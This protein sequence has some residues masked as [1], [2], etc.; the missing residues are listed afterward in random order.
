MSECFVSSWDGRYYEGYSLAQIGIDQKLPSGA[1]EIETD[2]VYMMDSMRRRSCKLFKC[3]YFECWIRRVDTKED[4]YKLFVL[5]GVVK[6]DNTNLDLVFPTPHFTAIYSPGKFTRLRDARG[7]E[8]DRMLQLYELFGAL[9]TY[10]VM[11]DLFMRDS[12]N[13]TSSLVHGLAKLPKEAA[14]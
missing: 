2:A 10:K 8:H 1:E 12:W 13:L 14:K 7:Y 11:Y 3:D 4:K 9:M 6:I 5:S